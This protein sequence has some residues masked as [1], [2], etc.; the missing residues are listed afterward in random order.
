MNTYPITRSILPAMWPDGGERPE[1]HVAVQDPVT[2]KWAWVVTHQV[3]TWL[4]RRK[5]LAQQQEG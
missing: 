5:R 3:E 1:S 2:D 4:K